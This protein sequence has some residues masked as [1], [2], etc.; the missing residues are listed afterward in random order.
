MALKEFEL[1]YVLAKHRT[2]VFS[3]EALLDKIWGYE[4]AGE[5]RTVDVHIRNLR[6]KIEEDDNKP[7]YI[8][9]VRGIG[10]KFS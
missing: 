7:K 2:R 6:K 10:Y 5:T 9:T 8:K 1:L 4:Y 3:R